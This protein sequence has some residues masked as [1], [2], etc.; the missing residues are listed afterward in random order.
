[1]VLASPPAPLALK[2][3]PEAQHSPGFVTGSELASQTRIGHLI[4]HPLAVVPPPSPMPAP[5][6]PAACLLLPPAPPVPP[7]VESEEPQPA[8]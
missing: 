4:V 6:A 2:A 8:V 3:H 5:A 1:M 7:L